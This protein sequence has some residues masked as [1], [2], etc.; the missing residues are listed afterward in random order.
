M[1][2]LPRSA[3]GDV[4]AAMRSATQVLHTAAERSGFVAA[5][6]SGRATQA[7]YVLWLRNL[8]I[9]YA[10]LETGLRAL[11]PG[12]PCAPLADAAVFRASALE[13]DLAALA[14]RGWRSLPVLPETEAYARDID[15]AFRGSGAGVVAHAYVRYLGDLN[16]GQIVRR[17]VARTLAVE[18]LRFYAFEGDAKVLETRYRG[19]LAAAGAAVGDDAG[20]AAAA[21][22]AFRLNIALSEAL[23]SA[24]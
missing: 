19:A 2:P 7:G 15:D 13:D 1:P 8:S 6:L 10:R 5:L 22:H 4:L 20:A 9:A 23:A 24:A 21:V 18:A 12:A 11:P 17:V 16:G 14:G 3:P